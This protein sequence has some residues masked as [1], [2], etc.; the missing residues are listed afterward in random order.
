MIRPKI[1]NQQ[2]TIIYRWNVLG[3]SLLIAFL[4]ALMVSGL[5]FVGSVRFGTA[6]S[7]TSVTGII[8]SDT[9][10]TQ[11]NSPYSLSGPV[12]ISSGVTLTIEP[13]T[14]V[15]LNNFYITV[16]GAL[17]AKGTNTDK[18]QINDISGAGPFGDLPI[19]FTYGIN[20]TEIS[21]GYNAQSDSGSIIEN[22]I[23]N[24]TTLALES[25]P[26]INNDII[27]GYISS[28]GS[29]IISNNLV[30]G[31]IHVTGSSTVLNNNI[32]GTIH[33]QTNNG[34]GETP[35]ISNNFVTGGGIGGEGISFLTD[36]ITVS[37]N[38]ISGCNVAGIA[39]EGVGVI[40]NNFITENHDGI[41]IEG[42]VI[43]RNN[44]IENN[45]IGLQQVNNFDFPIIVYN[46]LQ[47]NSYN[48][49]LYH[50][51]TNSLNATY[52]WWGTTD[53]TAISN[54]IYDNRDDSNLGTVN[55]VPFLTSPNPQAMPNPNVPIATPTP[56]SP[57][58]Q[59]SASL[60]TE[61]IVA[62]VVIVIIAVAIG[63]FLLGKRTGRK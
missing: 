32:N 22:A 24:S 1:L 63:A 36:N 52:N 55:F 11:A 46:N 14:T 10:W 16:N 56:T 33:V 62:V 7:G 6:Q 41:D 59:P 34:Q 54:S 37:G 43:L 60:P 18:I 13:G 5:A 31:E 15:N 49:F 61:L 9:T 8:G 57:S 4:I 39:A 47:N 21:V 23:I 51:V 26:S 35:V 17:V 45:Y 19:P 12:G 20:F 27:N 44:T 28:T 30:T 40:E 42:F 50:L 48:L 3:K 58:Q 2:T 38:T 29:S 25:S 53:Q